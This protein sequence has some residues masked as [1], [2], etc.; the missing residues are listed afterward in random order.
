MIQDKGSEVLQLSDQKYYNLLQIHR[1]QQYQVHF[2]TYFPRTK[3]FNS[4]VSMNI[5]ITF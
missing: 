3:V 1:K 2:K 4:P 5:A